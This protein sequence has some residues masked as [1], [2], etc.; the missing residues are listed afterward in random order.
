MIIHDDKIFC[1]L[2]STKAQ[3][4]NEWAARWQIILTKLKWFSLVLLILGCNS[5]FRKNLVIGRVILGITGFERELFRNKY[6]T[7]NSIQFKVG[8]YLKITF[9]KLLK[10]SKRRFVSRFFNEEYFCYH[11]QQVIRLAKLG[12]LERNAAKF[13]FVRW[14]I[15]FHSRSYGNKFWGRTK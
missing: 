4:D 12:L 13:C 10:F 2:R 5:V 15:S 8:I 1:A 14:K 6:E 9:T 11:P 7:F 3:M